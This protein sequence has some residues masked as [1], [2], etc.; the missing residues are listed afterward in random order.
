[1]ARNPTYNLCL[2]IAAN[3]KMLHSNI[4]LALI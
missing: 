1:M 2:Q 4:D 3:S